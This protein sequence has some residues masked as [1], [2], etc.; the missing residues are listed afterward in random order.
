[1]EPHRK[2]KR[3]VMTAKTFLAVDGNSI[4]NRAFYGIRTL[5]N[6]EGFHTNAIYGFL[7]ILFRHME[8]DKPDEICVA[9]DVKA[10]TYRNDLY[11]GYKAGRKGM[12]EELAQQVPKLKELLDAMG[13]PRLEKAGLEADDILGTL[14]LQ[15]TRAGKRCILVTGDR[16]AFQLIGPQVTVKL[17]ST[18]KTSSPADR[19]FDEK[20][21]RE[22]YGMTPAQMIDLKALM[23]DSSDNIPG[24]PGVGEKTATELI[25]QFGSLD[26]IYMHLDEVKPSL[27]TKL[28]NGKESAYLSKAL[29]TIVRDAAL[30][31]RDYTPQPVREADLKELLTQLELSRI[32]ARYSWKTETTALPQEI[33]TI[34]YQPEKHPLSALDRI[35]FLFREGCLYLNYQGK[36]L[37]ARPQ[38]ELLREMA[39]HPLIS[40]DIKPFL[41]LLYTNEITADVEFDTMLALYVL[42]PAEALLPLPEIIASQTK[43]SCDATGALLH[44][45]ALTEH[46]RR[47]LKENAAE[48]LYREI[49]LPLCLVLAR[50]EVVGFRVER[51][52]LEQFGRLAQKR[53]EELEQEI[54]SLA[55]KAFNINSPKQLGEV[56]FTD[57]QLPSGKKNKTGYSTNNETLERLTAYHPIA[58]LLIQYRQ[59]GK[60]KSTY[61][62]G[63]TEK[64]A[65]DGRIH[66]IFMQALTQTGRISSTEPN[67]QNIPVRT[68][69]GRQLR[70]AFIP[71]NGYVLVDADYSQIELR[72][73]AHIADDRNMQEAFRNGDDIHTATA[74]QVFNLPPE[75]VQPQMRSRAKAVNFGIVYGIGDFS[76]AKNLHI[77]RKEAKQYIESYL[78]TYTGVRD[79]MQRTIQ[80][81]KKHGYVETLFHRR[82]YIP[83]LQ[84]K[85]AVQRAFGER[86]CMNAPIQGTAADIIKLAMVKVDRRLRRE[87]FQARLILQIHDELIVEAPEEEASAVS[88]LL[89]EE[90]EQAVTLS[91]PLTVDLKVGKS[92]FDTK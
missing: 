86:I 63:L 79:Y 70:R 22:I 91:V 74:A 89:K 71:E 35:Y 6:R 32:A 3:Y 72:L 28:E 59:I 52:F 84:S 48:Y 57:L 80:E 53:L 1:M 50:M 90:M 51:E 15:A 56:L 54:F 55:G 25:H 29:G 41:K 5:T 14:S 78:A 13:I 81:G 16:D 26:A 8:E 12:P 46:L 43:I 40:H 21:L 66:T 2:E 30:P 33:Q 19:I 87:G 92:W 45:S 11:D 69:L 44:L 58:E 82:R 17:A 67:L 75:M 20:A 34:P 47:K 49:E 10:K 88:A 61:T 83:E 77:P 31:E 68:E 64:I 23:G 73:L 85:N 60:L 18:S 62:D 24:V 4:L 76:L 7:N 37:T 27:K 39:K 65:E 36:I 42:D 38:L 9:F